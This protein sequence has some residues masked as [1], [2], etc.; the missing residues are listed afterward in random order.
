MEFNHDSDSYEPDHGFSTDRLHLA[1][2]HARRR[3]GA[4]CEREAG[5]RYSPPWNADGCHCALAEL[6]LPVG[7]LEA[8]GSKGTREAAPGYRPNSKCA[9]EC[10]QMRHPQ[11][12]HGSVG[13][14]VPQLP[15]HNCDRSAGRCGYV[16][17]GERE[18]CS[19]CSLGLPSSSF[20]RPW[21]YGSFRG[22]LS[23]P[24]VQLPYASRRAC[25][26]KEIIEHTNAFASWQM[27]LHWIA[28]SEV[29]PSMLEILG[30]D[31]WPQVSWWNEE[32]E[33]CGST[34]LQSRS[35]RALIVFEYCDPNRGAL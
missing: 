19:Q 12:C 20:G 15:D 26:T 14:T 24:K 22:A 21:R 8:E 30:L 35:E 7:V 2:L 4:G 13:S 29:L 10:A 23:I 27:H 31:G 1:D 34:L 16:R 33:P 17:L 28:S 9:V 3:H 25:A 5:S 11:G 18:G 32:L 6:S